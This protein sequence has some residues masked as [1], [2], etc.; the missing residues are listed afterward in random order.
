[1]WCDL[2]KSGTHSTDECRLL[3]DRGQQLIRLVKESPVSVA[4]NKHNNKERNQSA[5]QS[6]KSKSQTAEKKSVAL[7]VAKD[8][9]S[10][11]TFKY[12]SDTNKCRWIHRL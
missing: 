5:S 8:F 1:M 10:C 6:N 2:H 11:P 4:T 7:T 12:E 9:R 3:K